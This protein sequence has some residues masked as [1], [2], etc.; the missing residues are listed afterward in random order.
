MPDTGHHSDSNTYQQS[1]LI[2]CLGHFRDAQVALACRGNL[3]RIG[4]RLTPRRT[5]LRLTFDHPEIVE[6]LADVLGL[7]LK[8]SNG[9]AHAT[10]P[11]M[12]GT[13]TIHGDEA[14]AA[15]A[16]EAD[17]AGFGAEV[18]ALAGRA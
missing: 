7:G 10:G 14:L 4:G 2:G 9:R 11:W 8:L 16:L 5:H 18:V 17:R 3:V 1:V 13:L 6:A 12:G 15:E